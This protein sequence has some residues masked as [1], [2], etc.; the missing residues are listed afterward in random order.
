MCG[1]CTQ[2]RPE[3][4]DNRPSEADLSQIHGI[5]DSV[6]GLSLAT[7]GPRSPHRR[8]P[9]THSTRTCQPYI[10]L[11]I[12]MPRGHPNCYRALGT[13]ITNYRPM[14]YGANRTPCSVARR[15]KSFH[16]SNP[17]CGCPETWKDHSEGVERSCEYHCSHSHD[18]HKCSVERALARRRPRPSTHADTAPIHVP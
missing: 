3:G 11:G 9:G 1:P 17:I 7:A 10:T 18:A 15:S 16:V 13:V 4:S 12:S 6:N 14:A 2:S 8:Y 5:I